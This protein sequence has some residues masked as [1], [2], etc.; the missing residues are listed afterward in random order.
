[1]SDGEYSGDLEAMLLKAI[2]ERG[3]TKTRR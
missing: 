2:M 3:A 1:V